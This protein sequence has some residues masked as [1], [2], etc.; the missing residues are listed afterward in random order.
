MP[1]NAQLTE[2]IADSTTS[3]HGTLVPYPSFPTSVDALM[4]DPPIRC[5]AG[6]PRMSPLAWITTLRA[7]FNPVNGNGRWAPARFS[8]GPT[9]GQGA[10]PGIVPPD[11]RHP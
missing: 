10:G 4:A 6:L 1:I 2:A 11:V 7:G 9:F 3:A 8:Q 5:A